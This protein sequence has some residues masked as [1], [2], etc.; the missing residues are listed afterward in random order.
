MASDLTVLLKARYNI[1]LSED[2]LLAYSIS[3]VVLPLPATA[4]ITRSSLVSITESCSAVSRMSKILQIVLRKLIGPKLVSTFRD[5]FFLIGRCV[6]T[7]GGFV[8]VANKF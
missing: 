4:F 6:F 3:V 5:A 1:L 7:V 2:R 8:G